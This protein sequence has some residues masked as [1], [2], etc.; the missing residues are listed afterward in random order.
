MGVKKITI[1]LLP[2]GHR[3]VRQIKMPK[4]FL[5][6]F[7][8]FFFFALGF[9]GWLIWDYVGLKGQ[10]SLLPS[11][12]KENK[13][14][15]LQLL[16]L[17]HKIDR[18]GQEMIRLREFN[19]KLKIMVNLESEED[20]SQFLGIGGSDPSLLSPDYNVEKAHKQLVRLMHRTVDDLESEIVRQTQET[21]ELYE[22]LSNQKL[23]LAHT[24][25]IWPTK[26][27]LSS[28]FGKRIS[29]FTNEKEFHKGLDISARM[30]T[31]VIAPADGIVSSTSKN[32][33]Y[34]LHLTIN[35]GYG[36]KTVYAH[37]HKS[38]VKKGARVKR[39]QEIALVGNSGRSTGPHLHY[40]VRLNG[41]PV[42]P[43]RYILN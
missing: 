41:V 15:E 12:E 23:V 17:A 18:T 20:Q 14:K 36:I 10:M 43:H 37:L 3:K 38:L 8:L 16:S 30:K 2:E 27:W 33:G 22:Y 39:G 34:G 32:H 29:P 1:V 21:T 9:M 13:V 11:L 35:H 42:N 19:Q 28:G 31:L 25:S 40:E 26:G 5:G 4:I 24:P 7:S 6:L